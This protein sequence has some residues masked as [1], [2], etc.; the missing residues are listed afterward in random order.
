MDETTG[1]ELH[2][3]NGGSSVVLLMVRDAYA[4]YVVQTTLDVV[5][6]GEEKRRLLEELNANSELLVSPF[7]SV[8][9]LSF[10]NSRNLPRFF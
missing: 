6:E 7:E 10:C 2:K 8:N 4:N 1:A 3:E 5:A 9:I